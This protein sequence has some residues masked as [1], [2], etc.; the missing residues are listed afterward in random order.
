MMIA[1]TP[2]R[3]TVRT[4]NSLRQI[5]GHPYF[6]PYQKDNLWRVLETLAEAQNEWI[7]TNTVYAGAEMD[8]HL[9]LPVIPTNR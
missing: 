6:G 4:A 3:T 2:K 8:S 7:G 5:P 1:A 9:L